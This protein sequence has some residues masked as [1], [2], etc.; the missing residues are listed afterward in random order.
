MTAAIQVDGL[1]QIYPDGTKAVDDVSFKVEEGEFFGFLGPN[2]AEKTTTIKVLTTLVEKA[3]G[4]VRVSGYDVEHEQERIRRVIGVQSQQT[5][6]D[7]DLTGRQNLQLQGQLQRMRGYELNARV[8]ELLGDMD[9]A[10]V[11]DKKVAYYSEGMKR[12]LDLASATVHRPKLLFLDEP[13]AGLDPQSKGKVWDMLRGLNRGSG[14]T[15]FMTTQSMDE[16]DRLCSRVAIIDWGRIVAEGAP[17]DLKRRVEGDRITVELGD[18]PSKVIRSLSGIAGDVEGVIRVMESDNGLTV[19]SANGSKAVPE[20]V[21]ALSGNGVRVK[22]ISLTIP[23]L[24]D[25]FLQVTGKTI[26]PEAPMVRKRAR[27]RRFH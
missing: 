13:T 6:V 9:L 5:A 3:S 22:S 4:T 15:I 20:I 10:Q 16:A 11:A 26:R 1:V 18:V 19:Y 21:A 25:V 7:G 12:R 14:V 27:H 24:D 17:N 23:S 2:G 8:E